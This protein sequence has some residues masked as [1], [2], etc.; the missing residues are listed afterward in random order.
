MVITDIYAAI[1]Q[2]VERI[3]GK[4]EVS[5]SSPDRG[6]KLEEIRK[7]SPE[8]AIISSF[9][10]TWSDFLNS[11]EPILAQSADVAT[12]PSTASRAAP[13]QKN[14]LPYFLRFPPPNFFFSCKGFSGGSPTT[15]GRG[16]TALVG[17][18]DALRALVLKV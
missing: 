8:R 10:P 2:L 14:P 12:P 1:A 17:V 16:G 11:L 7:L 6:S 5:G 3:H 15:S 9:L 13:H 18:A 4:D